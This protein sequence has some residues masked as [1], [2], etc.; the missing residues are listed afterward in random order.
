M[1][2]PPHGRCRY[3]E[4]RRK[5]AP[6]PFLTITLLLALPTV[7]HPSSAHRHAAF[8]EPRP[9]ALYWRPVR[10]MCPSGGVFSA[11]PCSPLHVVA[12]AVRGRARFGDCARQS[13]VA[14]A[15]KLKDK[16]AAYMHQ[17]AVRHVALTEEEERKRLIIV[18]DVHGC[19]EELCSLLDKVSFDST[20]DTLILTGD[21]VNKGPKSAD[22]V[23]FA[24]DVGARAVLGNHELLSLRARATMETEG[25]YS[26][27]RSKYAWTIDLCTED[28]NFLRS[29]PFTI[30]LPLHRAR[31]VHAGLIPGENLTKQKPLSLLTTRNLIPN[32]DGAASARRRRWVGTSDQARGVPWASKWNGPEHIY[33]GHSTR[34][35]VQQRAFSTGLDTGCVYGWKLTAAILEP[36]DDAYHTMCP[37]CSSPLVAPK[38]VIPSIGKTAI[39]SLCRLHRKTR[40]IS[41][42][43]SVTHST[44]CL[45]LHVHSKLTCACKRA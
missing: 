7:V 8:S 29:L 32:G 10:Y 25:K 14:W 37:I 27:A 40:P 9:A 1:E 15:R 20:E 35:S 16:D 23:R 18:G 38:Y 3:G 5:A 26:I 45:R 41:P 42:Y 19:Y 36:P 33:F 21:F 31:I 17:G 2:G 34:K 43:P 13:T 22:V 12:P 44:P 30:Q 11:P 24:R 28:V 4:G 39:L 6:W